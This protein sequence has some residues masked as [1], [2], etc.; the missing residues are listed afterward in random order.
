MKW[1]KIW[2]YLF[3]YIVLLVASKSLIVNSYESIV[4]MFS[5]VKSTNE[6][7]N[8]TSIIVELLTIT[9]VTILFFLPIWWKENWRNSINLHYYVDRAYLAIESFF[10]N[11]DLSEDIKKQKLTAMLYNLLIYISILIAYLVLI[12]QI[13][14]T[15]NGLKTILLLLLSYILIQLVDFLTTI[16]ERIDLLENNASDKSY[17]VKKNII[18]WVIIIWLYIFLL[19]WLPIVWYIYNVAN[20]LPIVTIFDWERINMTK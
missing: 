2:I 5:H 12:A 3:T 1:V 7:N 4:N 17:I 15:S 18:T 16:V 6:L 13:A 14:L 19:V 10:N 8:I 20:D 11:T 9:V